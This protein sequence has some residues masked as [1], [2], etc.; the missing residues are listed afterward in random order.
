MRVGISR[1]TSDQGRHGPCY[2]VGETFLAA[3]RRRGDLPEDQR[4]WLFGTARNAMLNAHRGQ[5]RRK[6]VAVRVM[7]K[8]WR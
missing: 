2:L 6:A 3:W 4:P 1:L 8:R 7:E 5:Q